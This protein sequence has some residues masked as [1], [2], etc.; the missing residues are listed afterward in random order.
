MVVGIAEVVFGDAFADN[1]DVL[2]EFEE[3]GVGFDTVTHEIAGVG[4]GVFVAVSTGIGVVEVSAHCACSFL[5]FWFEI[6][7][8]YEL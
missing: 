6:V 1:G 5:L 7:W 4:F 2:V 8:R 3:A